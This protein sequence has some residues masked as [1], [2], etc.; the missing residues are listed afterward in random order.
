MKS[1]SQFTTILLLVLLSFSGVGINFQENHITNLKFKHLQVENGLSSNVTSCI[2]QDKRGFLWFGTDAGLNCYDGFQIKTYKYLKNQD[3]SISNGVIKCLYEDSEGKIWIGTERGLN[4][5]DPEKDQF[6]FFLSKKEDSKTLSNN[7]ITSLI[8]DKYK[9]L[10]VGTFNGLNL[11]YSKTNEGKPVFKRFH[12]NT[13]DSSSL[14]SNRIFCLSSDKEGN[15]WIG[16]EGGGLNLIEMKELK[17]DTIR[18]RHFVHSISI[19]NSI[20]SNIIYNIRQIED[21]NVYVGTDEGLSIVIRKDSQ[22]H[23]HNYPKINEGHK[24]FKEHKVYSLAQDKNKD[25]WIGTFGDGLIHVKPNLESYVIYRHEPTNNQSLSRDFIFDIYSSREGILW[26]A[27]RETGIDRIDP[28]IQRFK[29]LRHNPIKKNS[30]SN[31]VIKSIAESPDGRFWFGTYGGGLN[32]FDPKTNTYKSYIHQPSTTNSL[33]SNIIESIAFDHL[34]RLWIGTSK[35]L[36]LFNPKTNKFTRFEHNPA[37]TNSL[38]NNDIWFVLPTRDKTGLW[39]ATYN[40]VDKYDWKKKKFYHYRN[41][42]NNPNS[43]SFNFTRAILEDKNHN[44]WISTWGGGLDKLDLKKYPD[45]ENVKFDHFRHNPENEKSISSDLVNITFVDSQNNLWVGTQGGLNLYRKTTNDFIRYTENEGLADNVIKGILEDKSGNLWIS[46]Q[47]GMSKFNPQTKKFTNHYGKDGLQGDIFNLSSCYYNSRNEMMFGGNNGVSVFN[48]ANISERNDFP[49]VYISQLKINNQLILTGQEYNGRKPITKALQLM[50]NIDLKHDENTINLVFSAIEYS[51]QEKIKFAYQLDGV[52]TDWN[53]TDYKNRQV[54]YSGLRPGKYTFHVRTTNPSGEWNHEEAKLSFNISP[55]FWATFYA[56]AFYVILIIS[57]LYYLGSILQNRI[58][59]KK[60]LQREK[61][62]HQKRIELNKF[63]LQFFT[64]VSHEIRTPL[65]LISLPLQKLMDESN[66]LSPKQKK[67]YFQSINRNVNLLLQLVNQLLDF[68]KVDSNK[69]SLKVETADICQVIEPIIHSFSTIGG[70]KD[71]NI[72]FYPFQKKK[73]VFV[74]QNIIEKILNNLLSN[75]FKFTPDGGDIKITLHD[76]GKVPLPP[77][78]SEKNKQSDYYCISVE[79]NG[80]GMPESHLNTIFERFTQLPSSASSETGT[81]I[82]LALTKKIVEAHKGYISVVSKPDKGSTFYVWLPS[83][84]NYYD[85]D[86]IIQQKPKGIETNSTLVS[87]E[88]QNLENDVPKSASEEQIKKKKEHSIL[89]IEDNDEMRSYIKDILIDQYNILEASNG[90]EGL[91]VALDKGPDIVITDVMMPV[92]NGLE[93]CNQLKQNLN[94]SH[95]PVVMLT[96][97]SSV[98]H[99]IE[100]LEHGADQY[101]AKPFKINLLQLTIRNILNNRRQLQMKFSA[102]GIPNPKEI[103]VTS[104][105]E[106]FFESLINTIEEHL[107]DP[108]FTVEQLANIVGLSSVHL[109]RK[110]KSISGVTP[111][112]FIR[113]YRLKSASQ[114]LKQNKLRISEVGYLVGFSDPK[115]FRKCFKNEFGISPSQYMTSISP[116]N[117]TN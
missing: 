20:A 73:L 91:Q 41:N 59:I 61:E 111:S 47:K 103:S 113:T 48:P 31:N 33:S 58:R 94:I 87:L 114:L 37:N 17:K 93:F 1:T 66:Q 77:E 98:E 18:F 5:Y 30:L 15:L 28:N 7:T 100:G 74:D 55:P 24:E 95:I 38:G 45:P 51:S 13:K 22:Y 23:F 75:A 82:G 12:H 25:I 49:P 62:E 40:G 78:Q 79:D 54:T 11:L 6:K 26:L 99:E 3:N 16:T 85:K 108:E 76:N 105:D 116:L 43:L 27:T 8:E 101:I 52:D 81:G 4:C 19:S 89:I 35:G 102:A 46:T 63:K 50:K 21:G 72:H 34:N 70:Q 10:W 106:K 32:V 69:I 104:A 56:K 39:I 88:T 65:T 42:P 29:H 117:N 44:L 86:E 67:D 60:E 110:L 92:M 36:N 107:S 64:N 115:Y 83:D 112:K 109:Y 57:S 9:R 96:A 97:K 53:H 90:E 68:R 80:I 14:T 71:I 84:Q 2:I